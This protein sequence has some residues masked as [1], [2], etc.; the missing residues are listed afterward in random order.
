MGPDEGDID[1]DFLGKR[2]SDA[3]PQTSNLVVEFKRFREEPFEFLKTLTKHIQSSSWRAYDDYIGRELYYPGFSDHIHE[4]TMSSKTIRDCIQ[5]LADAAMEHEKKWMKDDPET[6]S[7][8]RLEVEE[9]ITLIADKMVEEMICLFQHKG[10]LKFM[11]YSVAQMFSR[12]YHQGVHVNAEEIEMI[13]A[14][15]EELQAKKQS[16]LFMPCHKSH[17]DY[18][19]IQLICFR[20]GI[21]LPVV[22]AGENLNFA[23][24]GAM[25]RQVGAMYIRRS[26]GDDR[27]YQAVAQGYIETLLKNGYNFECF[28]E[29]TRSRTGKLLPP[30][31]G[32]LKYIMEALLSGEVEDAWI[33]PVSTQ[34]DKIVEG[35]SYATE[36]LGREKPKESFQNFLNDASK[37]LSLR[38]GRVDVRFFKPWSLKEYVINQLNIESSQP[39]VTNLTPSSLSSLTSDRKTHL[40]RSLGY[41][42]LSD[43]NKASVVMPTSLVGT[44]LLTSTGRGLTLKSLVTKVEWLIRKIHEAGGRV[45]TVSIKSHSCVVDKD[46]EAMVLNALKVLG[47]DMVGKEERGLTEPIY[48]AKDAFQLSYYRNQVIHLFVSE[49]IVTVAMYTLIRR[50]NGDPKI[51]REEL[52]TEVSFLSS[53]LSGEFVYGSQGLKDNLLQTLETLNR[54]GII[55]PCK[56]DDE[57]L[58]VELSSSELGKGY[59][60]FDFYCYLLWPFMDG[61]WVTCIAL[62]MLV[63]D[64]DDQ[65]KAIERGNFN[66]TVWVD[67]KEFLN[68]AQ[69]LGKTLYH[70]GLV[71]YY[72]SI[73]KELLKTALQQFQEEGVIIRQ[74]SK[75]RKKP[76]KISLAK[77]WEMQ[78]SQEDD[79][80][81]KYDDIIP[82]GKLY[83]FSELISESR[84]KTLRHHDMAVT[85][86]GSDMNLLRQCSLLGKKLKSRVVQNIDQARHADDMIVISQQHKRDPQTLATAKL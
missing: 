84:H 79:D 21:S 3:D 35:D 44:V 19:A 26:F 48:H 31:F 20:F 42:I 69:S 73:N 62:F 67:E 53:L 80:F 27:L 51:S 32:I 6:N 85:P 30:K 34:Y 47:S 29:G 76:P 37:I 15:A 66:V 52:L 25:L 75:D 86:K 81:F 49:A 55:H 82:S 54:Q 43:I 78:R 61:F 1:V 36:L 40:L 63:P 13:K 71:T 7:L 14:K 4:L 8:R 70:Q 18:I 46:F 50:S 23:V 41:R 11:Y 72:E 16:L 24:I 58:L 17:I 9:N 60:M 68:T 65:K 45:G 10:V 77:G 83:E 22:V 56:D 33:A 57:Y 74:Q 12:T 59:E 2:V 39:L 5:R 38:I 64:L 28:V